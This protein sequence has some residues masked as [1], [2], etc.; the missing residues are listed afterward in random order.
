MSQTA[1]VIAY[2][3]VIVPVFYIRSQKIF[4]TVKLTLHLLTF[5]MDFTGE[6]KLVIIQA[7]R[8]SNCC[9]IKQWVY[10]QSINLIATPSDI[11]SALML[12]KQ[13]ASVFSF[14][15]KKWLGCLFNQKA[16]TIFR[17]ENL[18]KWSGRCAC[19]KKKKNPTV[20]KK[21]LLSDKIG[22]ILN[23]VAVL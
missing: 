11:M 14:F 13:E 6:K 22:S 12:L 7:T 17:R 16:L 18:K 20:F 8:C 15:F 10:D 21:G 5:H 3:Y 9:E 2:T 19:S 4:Y 23:V 1:Q